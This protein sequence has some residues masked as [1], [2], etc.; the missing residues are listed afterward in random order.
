MSKI[1]KKTIEELDEILSRGCDYAATQEVVH[2]TF[3]ESLE[4]L[5]GCGDWDEMTTTDMNDNDVVLQ[6]LFEM[7]Y[8]KMIEKVM[9]ILKTQE[10]KNQMCRRKNARCQKLSVQ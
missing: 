7:F 6:D 8:D 4:E 5:G 10:Q 1:S 9:N 3:A 2:E